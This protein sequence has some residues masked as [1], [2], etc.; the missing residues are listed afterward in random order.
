M[1]HQVLILTLA[2]LT[3]GGQHHGDGHDDN[4]V[5][6]SRYSELDYNITTQEVC[7][8]KLE[9]SCNKREKKLCISVPRITCEVVAYPDCNNKKTLANQRFDTTEKQSFVTK[10]CKQ[11]GVEVLEE[12]KKMPVC[13]T[14]TKQQCDSK[15]VINEQGEKVW[16]GNE[17]CRDVSWE[18]CILEDKV[19]KE[20]VPKWECEDSVV[21]SYDYPVFTTEDV[22]MYERTCEPTGNPVCSQT[23]EVE[24]TTVEWDECTEV[25]KETCIPL[26]FNIPYQT[27]DHTLRCQ[28][29]HGV[30]SQPEET[31]PIGGNKI[32]ECLTKSNDCNRCEVDCMADC[33][34]LTRDGSKCFSEYACIPE[35]LFDVNTS[36]Y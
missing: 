15:W 30:P 33:T 17:N 22:A 18:D 9:K 31:L 34:D 6:T 16:D 3:L 27:Y 26:T 21:L 32:C 7:T 28:I 13:T 20:E 8:F 11:T 2:G 24:C 36:D 35:L 19:I 29:E 10:E 23:K 4:C 5:D 1:I 12:V 25:V 14:V